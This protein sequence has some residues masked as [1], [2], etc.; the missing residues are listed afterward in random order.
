MDAGDDPLVVRA[1]P[2]PAAGG[3]VFTLDDLGGRAEDGPVG[4][5]LVIE[6][7]GGRTAE[8]QL[9]VPPEPPGPAVSLLLDGVTD[10]LRARGVRRVVVAPTARPAV[11]A[12]ALAAAGFRPS[13]DE[14]KMRWELEL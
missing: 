8:L 9:L 14:D 5:A 10:A 13:A 4:V 1:R 2:G 12:R 7:E 3:L 6:T 11:L